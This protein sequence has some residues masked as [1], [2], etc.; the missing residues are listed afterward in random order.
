MTAPSATGRFQ[1]LTL[2][3]DRVRRKSSWTDEEGTVCIVALMYPVVGLGD[4]LR[5]IGA[6]SAAEDG[7]TSYR[8]FLSIARVR[9]GP[10]R[11]EHYDR[12]D[13]KRLASRR[14]RG[15]AP[16]EWGDPTGG[17]RRRG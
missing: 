4:D 16:A 2:S 10:V 9:R 13:G 3:V 15:G 8:A 11:H 6:V 7:A 12:T 1:H 5:T 17:A 14:S